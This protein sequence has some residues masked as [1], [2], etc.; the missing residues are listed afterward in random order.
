M[1]E[2]KVELTDRLRR[3]GRWS[4]A[5]KLKDTALADFRAKGMKRDE[6]GAA[7]WE[8]MAEAYPPLPEEDV[9]VDAGRVQGLQDIPESWP[10]IPGNASLQAELRWCTAN[11]LR[12]VEEMPGG[13]IR[14]HLE[15]AGSPAP[16]WGAL[17]WLE[18]AI[19]AYS[20]F[21]DICA[22]YL[23]DEEDEQAMVK[24]EKAS[25]EE[26]RGLLAEMNSQWAEEL[27]A[28]TDATIRENVCSLVDDWARRSGLE[29]S[30]KAK[31]DLAAHV[32]EL[33]DKC[34]GIL[35]P[36]AEGE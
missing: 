23:K 30:N 19:R 29:V 17:S 7:A 26:V 31:F 6:A 28:N 22:R 18:T 9:V 2:S 21:T 5:S 10:E 35:A 12:V 15:R 1:N 20:K 34:V 33:V 27:V 4:E 16:S 24:R 36:S 3:E 32:G 13:V 14:V 8:A 25:I 11:R